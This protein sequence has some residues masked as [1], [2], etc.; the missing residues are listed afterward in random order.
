MKV[1]EREKYDERRGDTAVNAERESGDMS[2]NAPAGG[3]L[4]RHEGGQRCEVT[5]AF[6]VR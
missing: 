6:Q 1:S 4:H 5:C 3:A 2:I